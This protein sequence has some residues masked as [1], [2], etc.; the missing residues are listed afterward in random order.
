MVPRLLM[1][2][3]SLYRSP[4]YSRHPSRMDNG[5]ARQDM[6]PSSVCLSDFRGSSLKSKPHLGPSRMASPL[7][8]FMGA[9]EYRCLLTPTSECTAHTT[10]IHPRTHTDTPTHPVNAWRLR[11]SLLNNSSDPPQGLPHPLRLTWRLPHILPGRSPPDN[12]H[13][14]PDFE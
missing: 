12:K 13:V 6:A 14:I 3:I 1:S 11:D 10:D 8:L 2:E 5:K 7:S 4:L 9:C